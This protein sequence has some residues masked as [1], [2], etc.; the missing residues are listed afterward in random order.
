MPFDPSK[1]LCGRFKFVMLFAGH[2]PAGVCLRLADHR[3]TPI[4]KGFE[5]RDTVMLPA[6]PQESGFGVAI[7]GCAEVEDAEV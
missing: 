1:H 4:L 3:A 2:F 7:S 5:M 6:E